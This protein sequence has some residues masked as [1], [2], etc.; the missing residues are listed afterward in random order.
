MVRVARRC[1][2]CAQQLEGAGGAVGGR[3]VWMVVVVGGWPHLLQVVEPLEA[4]HAHRIARHVFAH[5]AALQ[6]E[7]IAFFL[8]FVLPPRAG[9]AF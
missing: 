6:L 7:A 4:D 9:G 5:H 3:W 2:C 8:E 1:C